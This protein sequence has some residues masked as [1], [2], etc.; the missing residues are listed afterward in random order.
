MIC[1]HTRP[2]PVET[3]LTRSAG[4][5]RPSLFDRT[6]FSTRQGVGDMPED[7]GRQQK[8]DAILGR[9]LRDKEF[10]E[11]LVAD[12]T[13]AA[14]EA[15]LSPEE[16]QLVAGG[17]AIGTRIGG[18]DPGQVMWCTE[19]TC[20]EK[21]GARVVVF[22]PDDAFSPDVTLGPNPTTRSKT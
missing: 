12:P 7:Q 15:G 5:P 10:R 16:L 17:L 4:A 13:Q 8:L 1:C 20:N 22:S 14:K 19:K 11:R 9:A 21:G 6:D 18:P 2:K 3:P